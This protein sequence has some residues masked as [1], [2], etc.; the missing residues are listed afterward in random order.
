MRAP[1]LTFRCFHTFP[2]V[3]WP[4]E[5]I[6]IPFIFG[7]GD[8]FLEEAFCFWLFH[9]RRLV[10]GI[11]PIGYRQP[12]VNILQQIPPRLGELCPRP[13]RCY[14]HSHAPDEHLGVLLD[15]LWPESKAPTRHITKRRFSASRPLKTFSE[16]K[17]LSHSTQ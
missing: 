3:V 13:G 8:L 1:I 15:C 14:P 6:K 16:C 4:F 17:L 5:K 12:S 9:F 7:Q 10:V 2:F 11:A